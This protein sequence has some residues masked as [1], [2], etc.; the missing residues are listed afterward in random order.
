MFWNQFGDFI[1]LDSEF[2]SESA[3]IKFCGSGY[4]QC[5]STSLPNNPQY[6]Q[7]FYYGNH[8]YVV[9]C[10]HNFFFAFKH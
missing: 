1:F 8:K 7:K 3:L 2:G 9:K 6:D 10:R 4:D 5:G